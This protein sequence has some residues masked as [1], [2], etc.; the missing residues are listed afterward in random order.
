M[1]CDNDMSA[2]F[3]FFIYRFGTSIAGHV[4]GCAISKISGLTIKICTTAMNLKL[5]V[6]LCVAKI[7]FPVQAVFYNCVML[8]VSDCCNS[9]DNTKIAICLQPLFFG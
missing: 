7:A 8:T 6:L 9:D 4:K 3:D 2:G 1:V 5:R